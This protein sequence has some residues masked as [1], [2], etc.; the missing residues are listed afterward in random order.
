MAGSQSALADSL[1][2]PRSTISAWFGRK[3]R[4][5]TA[6]QLW[7][8]SYVYDV[9]LDWLFGFSV[10]MRRTDR[11]RVGALRADLRQELL[12]A[13]KSRLPGA[14][15]RTVE[16]VVG[17]PDE[18]WNLLVGQT[19]EAVVKTEHERM[20]IEEKAIGAG[21]GIVQEVASAKGK[22]DGDLA[23]ALLEMGA[24]PNSIVEPHRSKMLALG[25][26]TVDVPRSAALTSKLWNRLAGDARRAGDE[27]RARYLDA[28]GA[29]DAF[30]HDRDPTIHL[31]AL[32][33]RR[34][35]KSLSSSE[36]ATF[37]SLLTDVQDA[38]GGFRLSEGLEQQ[39]ALESR[40]PRRPSPQSR[41]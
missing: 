37:I 12:T 23:L 35:L 9:S 32:A 5:A 19:S 25:G 38:E 24:T 4:R 33:R 39:Q 31:D 8:I 41:R 27:P 22:L 15:P 14:L 34:V 26:L 6:E 7:T 36:Q 16:A 17:G 30:L 2:E 13:V 29:L 11:E 1:G 18:L 28:C 40:G 21:L 3:P 10:P 20:R